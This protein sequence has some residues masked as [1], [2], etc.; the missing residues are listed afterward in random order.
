[1]KKDESEFI[2]DQ[3]RE[4]LNFSIT[5]SVAMTLLIWTISFL[6]S[7]LAIVAFIFSLIAAFKAYDGIRYRYPFNL[8]L[9]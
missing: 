8:R 3:A 9:I 4:A 1:M 5:M 2:A 7:L 6:G